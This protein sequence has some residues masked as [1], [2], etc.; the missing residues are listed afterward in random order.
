MTVRR[1]QATKITK[2]TKLNTKHIEPS[3]IKD[4]NLVEMVSPDLLVK[5]RLGR[6]QDFK[7][8]IEEAAID[9]GPRLTRAA[10]KSVTQ[11]K[12]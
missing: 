12:S 11:N 5:R 3:Y 9:L 6:P 10:G 2:L 8:K 1:P 7:Q 4:I